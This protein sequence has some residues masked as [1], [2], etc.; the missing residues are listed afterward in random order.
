[1]ELYEKIIIASAMGLYL[2]FLIYQNRDYFKK[3]TSK[4]SIILKNDKNI[5]AKKGTMPDNIES[6]KQKDNIDE[7]NPDN[8]IRIETLDKSGDFIEII[9]PEEDKAKNKNDK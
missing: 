3:H 1:M 6:D 5:I 4:K 2:C 8:V 9:F 7:E